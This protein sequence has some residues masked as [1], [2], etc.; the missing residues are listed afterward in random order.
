MIQQNTPPPPPSVSSQ[1]FNIQVFSFKSTII[2]YFLY[3]VEWSI[4]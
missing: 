3:K 4:P 1:T 2:K